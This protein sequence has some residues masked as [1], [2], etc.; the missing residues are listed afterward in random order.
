ME[1]NI[2][3][4]AQGKIEDLETGIRVDQGKDIDMDQFPVF[5]LEVHI[6][7]PIKLCFFSRLRFEMENSRTM[8]RNPSRFGIHRPVA[9]AIEIGSELGMPQDPGPESALRAFKAMIVFE[10][11][12]ENFFIEEDLFAAFG[13]KVFDKIIISIDRTG[14]GSV[15]GFLKTVEIFIDRSAID[16]EFTGNLGFVQFQNTLLH[17]RHKLVQI[18]QRINTQRAV[19]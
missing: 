8:R 14:S 16:I 13:Q 3:F 5:E 4:P 7:F 17:K 2:P 10:I 12:P 9:G 18:C 19:D 6:L 15:F 1:K 11:L